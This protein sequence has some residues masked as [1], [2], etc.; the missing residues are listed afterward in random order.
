MLRRMILVLSIASTLSLTAYTYA[1][2]TQTSVGTAMS[3]PAASGFA[4]VNGLELYYEIHGSGMPLILLHGGVAASEVFGANLAK[5]AAGRQV[6]AVHLQGHGR[7]RDIDRPLR[8]EL[9]ADDI[10]TLIAH[11][12]LEKPDVMGY[13]MG[14]GVAI[15]T[16]IRHPEAVG[17]LVV[18]SKSMK[19][20]GVYPEVID[21]FDQ[22]AANAPYIAASVKQSPLAELY[23][24]VDWE[25]TFTKIA[26]MEG[27]DYDWSDGVAAITS[28]TMLVFADA[29]AIRPDHIV[30]FYKLLGGGRRDA[31][32]DGSA[33]PTARLAIVPGTT[34]Y[35]ILSTT[36]VAEL[37]A[38]FLDAP[39]QEAK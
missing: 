21:A 20:D 6:I 8:Y 3:T 9:M 36:V 34:H 1:Q 24:N 33:R 28:P 30:E 4:A 29:D 16:A 13:S 39:I 7:T 32:L 23:P 15:Q 5:L 14:G 35:D 17:K 11:L 25:V 2:T 19:R 10:A 22:M 31:G 26:G 37:V 12:G 38:P 27:Q 18:V